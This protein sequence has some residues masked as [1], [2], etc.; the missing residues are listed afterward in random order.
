M[1][2]W[3]VCRV[4][5]GKK[6]ARYGIRFSYPL[7]LALVALGVFLVNPYLLS[8]AA[9]IAFFGVILPMHPFDYIYN[10]CVSRLIGTDKI[11][12]RGS[13]LQVNSG[14]ALLFFLG[15]LV[16]I[17][18]KIQ[19]NYA[20]MALLYILSSSFFIT[21]QL[22]TDNFSLYSLNKSKK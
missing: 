6:S 20:V 18:Y 12:G 14:L 13:E 15:V 10:Y 22:F 7:Y 21:I 19:L 2:N 4:T 11:P 3:F 1:T 16:S 9:L 5:S 8:I 17:A